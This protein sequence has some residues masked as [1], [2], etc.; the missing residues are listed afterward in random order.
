MEDKIKHQRTLNE[1]FGDYEKLWVVKP[2]E[3]DEI[4]E[5]EARE[6]RYYTFGTVEIGPGIDRKTGETTTWVGERYDPIHDLI[7][8]L[9]SE[10]AEYT[11]DDFRWSCETTIKYTDFLVKRNGIYNKIAKS[12][13]ELIKNILTRRLLGID[14][15]KVNRGV[16][17]K[18]YFDAHYYHDGRLPCGYYDSFDSFNAET[19]GAHLFRHI[20]IG[21]D[22][23]SSSLD[24]NGINNSNIENFFEVLLNEAKGL[25]DELIKNTRYYI[26]KSREVFNNL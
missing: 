14:V 22:S 12:H 23:F 7:N 4:L 15:R 2:R 26:I 17:N 16:S 8:R 21:K 5:Q 25:P 6:L 24:K 18:G 1:I 13:E 10:D 20:G 9:D 3:R 19:F 11:R